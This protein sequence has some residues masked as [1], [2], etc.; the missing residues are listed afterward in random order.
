L[1]FG[2]LILLALGIPLGWKLAG[3][4]ATGSS[5]P[6][7]AWPGTIE[8]LQWDLRMRSVPMAQVQPSAD[9][10]PN[11]LEVMETREWLGQQPRKIWFQ[12]DFRKGDGLELD[13]TVGTRLVRAQLEDLD[14]GGMW[15]AGAGQRLRT[16][17][18]VE[19]TLTVPATREVEAGVMRRCRLV[20]WTE[21]AVWVG[22]RCHMLPLGPEMDAPADP[23]LLAT[24]VRRSNGEMA[25]A[26]PLG[27]YRPAT[28]GL[29][30]G[31]ASRAR[32]L[33]L[34]WGR[35]GA[36]W[37]WGWAG[38]GL[39]MAVLGGVILAGKAAS[40]DPLVDHAEKWLGAGVGVGVLFLGLGLIRLVLTPPL[41]GV[42][43]GTQWTAVRE[44]REPGSSTVVQT[45]A[46]R[47][48]HD[49]IHLRP[50]QKFT[51]DDALEPAPAGAESRR[52]RLESGFLNPEVRWPIWSRWLRWTAW[53]WEGGHEAGQLFR[54]RWM[55]LLAAALGVGLAAALMARGP[56]SEAGAKWLGSM[57]LWL[58]GV[59]HLAMGAS[60]FGL[61]VGGMAV[62][63]AAVA[64]MVNQ[65]RQTWRT[66]GV[67]GLGMGVV[68]QS[69]L[70]AVLT[71][72]VLLSGLLGLALVRSRRRAR[73]EELE[74]GNE[75]RIGWKG[76]VG[77]GLGLL[78]TWWMG[79][80]VG[81][82]EL[83]RQFG[84][85]LGMD[86]LRYPVILIL[87]IGL[88]M[89]FEWISSQ[90]WGLS[91]GDGTG[92][93]MTWVAGLGMAVVLGL[94]VNAVWPVTPMGT[95]AERMAFWE[96]LPGQ[97]VSLPRADVAP[98]PDPTWTASMYGWRT[99]AAFLVSW[100]PGDADFMMSKLFWQMSGSW[101]AT[102]PAW[103]R[104]LVGTVAA[105]GL[106]VTFWRIAQRRNRVRLGRLTLVLGGVVVGLVALA[107]GS[108]HRQ[109]PTSVNGV[110][111]LGVY[112]G[113]IPVLFLGW[114]GLLIHWEE[115]HP[116]RLA[117]M[118]LGP[119]LVI[120]AV[121]NV[122]LLNRFL[123]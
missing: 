116:V 122:A 61:M 44:W 88:L 50:D 28:Q 49:R 4:G 84:A 57:W 56:A 108:L 91:G 47:L 54:L 58:P 113:F 19:L 64:S 24:P 76:W 34:M 29:D 80:G 89:G 15:S 79:T 81:D 40:T 38:L 100:G 86:P 117:M 42:D 107:V 92:K 16:G 25:W 21:D 32:V 93:G 96:M 115:K 27:G 14:G 106:G 37:V 90:C 3:R 33:G 71:S 66:M 104:W 26:Y 22:L 83:R 82:A 87:A 97:G 1:W 13:A 8:Q 121:S 48:H 31:G 43:E 20:V 95:L 119:A 17:L 72:V 73:A 112:L 102:G 60:P 74:P 111:A 23:G 77:L 65:D 53:I 98:P 110:S 120:H 94:L 10:H 9:G 7:T 18:P 36:G 12:F 123:G 114:K 78:L 30:E 51:S 99:V 109:P 35:E 46:Q 39:G 45:V 63:G 41:Q 101:E 52:W 69:G 11:E 70:D 67:W 85:I 59:S 68:L 103:I 118:I 55:G 2:L 6:L 62:G 5:R 105:L 75:G